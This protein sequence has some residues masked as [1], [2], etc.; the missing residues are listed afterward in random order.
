MKNLLATRLPTVIKLDNKAAA[1]IGGKNEINFSGLA[2]SLW[3]VLEEK[4]NSNNLGWPFHFTK[5]QHLGSFKSWQFVGPMRLGI[6]SAYNLHPAQAIQ[7]KDEDK[8]DREFRLLKKFDKPGI[9]RLDVAN[10]A[11]NSS[12][13]IREFFKDKPS[14]FVELLD[15]FGQSASCY[16]GSYAGY[17]NK[18]L[19]A[20]Q[21]FFAKNEIKLQK[22]EIV[23]GDSIFSITPKIYESLQLKKREEGILFIVPNFG[24]HIIQARDLGIKTHLLY[25]R[26]ESKFQVD[27]NEL[28]QALD[29]NPDISIISMTYPCNPTGSNLQEDTARKMAKVINKNKYKDQIK[30]VIQDIIMADIDL[31]SERKKSFLMSRI[32]EI[33]DKVILLSGFGKS[34]GIAYLGISYGL[35]KLVPKLFGSAEK[36]IDNVPNTIIQDLAAFILKNED[37]FKSLENGR[38]VCL[39]KIEMFKN[40]VENLNNILSKKYGNNQV[41]VQVYDNEIESGNVLLIDFSGLRGAKLK[42]YSSLE[43]GYD[44]AKFI[45]DELAVATVPGECFFMKPDEMLIRVSLAVEKDNIKVIFKDLGN[46]LIKN[47]ENIPDNSPKFPRRQDNFVSKDKNLG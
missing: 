32:E 31:T 3:Q 18:F 39:E 16:K 1:V 28:E 34:Y 43:S 15:V 27:V 14:L 24:Y 36:N 25:T 29:E 38:K 8:K 21:E 13:Q 10:S 41:Y 46:A 22:Q 42:D 7:Y 35:G 23:V 17:S 6:R 2:K 40:E 33:S 11:V 26:K 9:Y 19:S 20:I 44:I 37:Q 4:N 12:P 47:I 45:L 5:H 30:L